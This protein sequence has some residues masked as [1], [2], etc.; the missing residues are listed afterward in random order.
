MQFQIASD[1]H[2]EYNNDTVPDVDNFIKPETDV[3]ILPGDIGSLYKYN[4]LEGFLQ[5]ICKMFK[6]VIY[7]PGNNEY[8]MQKDIKP[9]SLYVLEQ[10]LRSIENKIEN[11]YV[12]DKS[13]IKINDVCIA[14]CTL[15]SEPKGHVPKYIVRIH[16]MNTHIY[17]NKFTKDSEY[18]KKITNYCNQNNLKLI[19]VTHHVPSYDIVPEAR[20]K[21]KFIS[22]YA[23]DMNKFIENNKID[24]WI[25]GHMH[26]NID[27]KLG[28]TRFV[29]NQMGK[30][31]DEIKDFKKSFIITV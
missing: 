20:K 16:G 11:L 19:V 18:I 17:K 1:L 30:P 8:Y 24:T 22:L 14:G 6:I 23:S 26:R 9:L 2:I 21:D 29:T 28:D 31:K 25:C 5:K 10:R 13:S 15:W 3:L 27:Q 4:Q 7:I 12:L